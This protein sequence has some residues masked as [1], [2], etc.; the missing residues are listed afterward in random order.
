MVQEGQ[1]VLLIGKDKL[2]GIGRTSQKSRASVGIFGAHTNSQRARH[3]CLCV[4]VCVLS[5][6]PN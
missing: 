4:C 6:F 5:L 2:D 3:M 1:P